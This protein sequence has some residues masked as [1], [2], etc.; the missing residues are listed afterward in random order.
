MKW[1]REPLVHFLALGGLVFLAFFWFGGSESGEGDRIVVSAAQVEGLAD[2]FVSAWQR[3]P[4][5][6]ELAG[7]VAEHVREEILYRE[8]LAMGLAENDM[9]VRQRM[10]QKLE[11][12]A[13]ELRDPAEPTEEELAAYL[14]EHRELFRVDSRV[15]FDHVYFDRGRRGV[16]AEED[17]SRLRKRLAVEDELDTADLGDRLP[18]PRRYRN[19]AIAGIAG[20]FGISFAEALA[21]LP[22]GEWS[23][24]VE[25]SHG[26]HLVL[27]RDRTEGRLPALEE[28]RDEVLRHFTAARREGARESFY[29]ELRS[30]YE[31]VVEEPTVASVGE[32]K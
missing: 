7:L 21:D 4:T 12:L 8:A 2:G 26:L 19:A 15:S 13:A 18:L 29:G 27:L 20:R 24:P 9:V 14:A 11:F 28:V 25:S 16:A 31:V 23:G 32:G 17:A 5:E 1:L 30:R 3:P 22:V 10:R 6:S